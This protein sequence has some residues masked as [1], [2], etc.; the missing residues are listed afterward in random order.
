MMPEEWRRKENEMGN[1]TRKGALL[2]SLVMAMSSVSIA[3]TAVDVTAEDE[4]VAVVAS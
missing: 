4:A 3:A 2:L 1:Y